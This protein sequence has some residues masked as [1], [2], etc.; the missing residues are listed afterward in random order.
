[1]QLKEREKAV[2]EALME[3]FVH[4]AGPVSS[5]LI[6]THFGLGVSSATIR[7]V[8]HR[9]E[10]LGLLYQPHTS[11]GRVPTQEGYRVYVGSFCRPARLP[12]RWL[13]HIQDELAGD[14]GRY[15]VQELL[16]RISRLLA[17]LSS[18]LGF[19]VA[20][21]E[22]QGARIERVEVVQLEGGRLLVVVTLDD[23]MVRTCL[24]P[25]GHRV[26]PH[27]LQLA[28][29]MLNEIVAGCTPSEARR[30]LEVALDGRPDEAGQIAH[31]VARE[32]ERVFEDRTPMAVHVEGAT[33]IMAEPEFRDP[34]NLRLLVRILDHPQ[35]LGSV[36]IGSSDSPGSASIAIGVESGRASLPFSLVAAGVPI[37]GCTARIGILGPM[38]MRYDLA[39]ALVNRV[40]E[41]LGA[42]EETHG[43]EH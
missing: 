35:D 21:E 33:Q 5:A 8:L 7:N 6:Q 11:A 26:A 2:L 23:G 16:A 28:E 14:A 38:R 15:D 41:V 27:S 1:M 19:G 20:V 31:T 36:Q 3:I 29:A 32:R 18:N 9:L 43:Q 17:G 30:R 40:A 12:I 39:I 25:L 24:L 22:H 13:R 4:E 42:R 10:D 37:A 34:E